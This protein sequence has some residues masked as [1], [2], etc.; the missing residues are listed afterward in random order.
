MRGKQ[1]GLARPRNGVTVTFRADHDV[2]YNLIA[3]ARIETVLSDLSTG[4]PTALAV[5]APPLTH[6]CYHP[7]NKPTG[8]RP[9]AQ[10]TRSPTSQTAN[11]V[12]D[13][14]RDRPC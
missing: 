11:T 13:R 12:I 9:S 4:D 10:P 1:F 14:A 7:A 8:L 2:I 6:P 5:T 3:N